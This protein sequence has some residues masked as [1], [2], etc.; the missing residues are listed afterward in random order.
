MSDE[1]FLLGDPLFNEF[2]HFYWLIAVAVLLCLILIAAQVETL[3]GVIDGLG[4]NLE[5][6]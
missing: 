2:D 6:A 4:L 1:E 3:N 5:E